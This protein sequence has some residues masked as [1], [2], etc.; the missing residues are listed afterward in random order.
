MQSDFQKDFDQLQSFTTDTDPAYI[1][2]KINESDLL[3]LPYVPASAKVRDKMVYASTRNTLYKEIGTEKFAVTIFATSKNDLT[4]QTY[5]SH[6]KS[7]AGEKPESEKEK[8]LRFV[9]EAETEAHGTATRRQIS[10]GISF[11]MSDEAQSALENLK[12]TNE[13]TFLELRIN[14]ETEMIELGQQ[15]SIPPSQVATALPAESPRFS[16][17]KSDSL[18]SFIYTCPGTSKVKER[19]LYSSSRGVLLN[20]LTTQLGLQI[21][22]KIETSDCVDVTEELVQQPILHEVKQT[23]GFARPKPPAYRRIP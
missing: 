10:S 16:L 18:V 8:A 19:M 12:T 21:D 22:R 2:Y 4:Y 3:F 7:E 1:L 20:Y 14:T 15:A 9:R 13:Q 17:F 5:D 11:P 23:P 6:M